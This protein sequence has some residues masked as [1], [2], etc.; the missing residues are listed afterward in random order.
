MAPNYCKSKPEKLKMLDLS[1]I[2][3]TIKNLKNDD[4]LSVFKLDK[5]N[6]FVVVINLFTCIIYILYFISQGKYIF[7]KSF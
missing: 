3:N 7:V 6:G 5:P 4:N 1:E 2:R